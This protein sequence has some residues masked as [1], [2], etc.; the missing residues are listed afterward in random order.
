MYKYPTILKELTA[1]EGKPVDVVMPCLM[2][3]A[4]SYVCPILFFVAP[5]LLQDELN[6]HW[7]LHLEGPAS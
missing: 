2:L 6:K 5:L 3:M 7:K 4:G 1:E